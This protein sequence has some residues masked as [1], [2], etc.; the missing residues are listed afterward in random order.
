M[1]FFKNEL[2]YLKNWGLEYVTE[3]GLDGSSMENIFKDE[4]ISV[5]SGFFVFKC[6]LSVSDVFSLSLS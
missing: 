3:L 4:F 5:I 6:W 1:I 2:Q